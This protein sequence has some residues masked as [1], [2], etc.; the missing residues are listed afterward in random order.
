MSFAST[1]SVLPQRPVRV[2]HLTGNLDRGGIETWLVNVFRRADPAAV[3][4]DVLVASPAPHTGV[5]EAELRDLGVR[6]IHAP[7]SGNLPQF[8]QAYRRVLREYGPYDV[9]H[10]HIHHF[11]GL[12]LLLARLAGVPVRVATSHTDTSQADQQAG[13]GRAAYLRAMRAALQGSVTHRTAVSQAAASALFGPDWAS[14]PV[15]IITLGIDLAG[16]QTPRPVQGLRDE[17]GLQPGVPVLGCVAQLRPEKNHMFL[18]DVLAEHVRRQGPAYLLLVG[19]GDERSAIEARVAELGLQPWVKLLGSRPDV[20]EL[21]WLMDA[22]LLT[23]KFEGLSLAFI[24]AQA[25]GLPCIVSTGVPVTSDDRRFPLIDVVRL[26]LNGDPAP[27]ADALAAALERGRHDPP[28]M[29]FEVAETTRE[30][31]EFYIRASRGEV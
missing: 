27:W 8:V 7:P 1:S 26:P 19:E 17:L 3:Q 14:Q 18:L 10:S 13:R 4:M 6:I 20:A 5:Y 28:R 30:L 25:V 24:E 15:Q 22:F 12:L 29:D 2:L 16:L 9:V 21:L 23:S 31:T 11:G